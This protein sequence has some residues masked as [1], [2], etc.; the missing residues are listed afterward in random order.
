MEIEKYPCQRRGRGTRSKIKNKTTQDLHEKCFSF[1]Y[2][3]IDY[4]LILKAL[5]CNIVLTSSIQQS[6]P[7]IDIYFYQRMLF[8][9]KYYFDFHVSDYFGQISVIVVFIMF[10][11]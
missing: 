8:Y 6:D 4:P 5:I 3:F 7:V 11:L 10:A 9:F 2:L 1:E